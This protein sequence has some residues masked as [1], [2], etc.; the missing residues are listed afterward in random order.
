[1]MEVRPGRGAAIR[2]DQVHFSYGETEMAFDL[3]VEASS[4]TAV[5]G[6]S[7]SGKSTLLNLIAGFERPGEGRILIGG[8]D[9]TERPPA[10]RPVSM[11]F[12]ENNLFAHLDVAANVGLG[13]SPSL[14]LGPEDRIAV[15][16]ALASVG[17]GGKEKRLPR[18]LSGGER[19][20]VA[21]AR[22]LVRDRPVLLLDEPFASLG[23]ALRVEM[24]DLLHDLHEK[25]GMTVLMVTHN[26]E[27]A[28][29]LAQLTVMLEAG[30]IA[31]VGKTEEVFSDGGPE[32]L[33][34]YVGRNVARP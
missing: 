27:D 6:P 20:R 22:V 2:L 9:V 11:V 25:R 8:A 5:I 33:R 13:R 1:M 16:E 34:R 18:E 15:T 14:R 3:E 30:R 7:G 17:L 10:L 4:I 12:Q 26:P 31:A 32:A 28:L 29:R 23:P 21:L 19:Q 24:L